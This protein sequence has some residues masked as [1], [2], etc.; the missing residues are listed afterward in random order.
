MTN[1]SPAFQFYPGDFLS[2]ENVISMTFEER[3]L[4]ITLLSN[5][6]IQGSIPSDPDK[7]IKLLPGYSNENGVPELVID[8]FNE[9]DGNSKRLVHPRLDKERTK[10]ADF[11]EA[12]SESGKRGAQKR[13]E[14]HQTKPLNGSAIV[15]P[16]AKNSSLSLSSSSSSSLNLNTHTIYENFEE[17]WN[18]YP[19]KAGN[20]IKARVCYHKS[21]GKDPDKRKLFLE[22]M[23]AYVSN[24]DIE[25]LKHGETFFR[26]WEALVVDTVKSRKNGNKDPTPMEQA[27]LSRGEFVDKVT[28]RAEALYAG[29]EDLGRSGVAELVIVEMPYAERQA[30]R[31]ILYNYQWLDNPP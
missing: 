1:K 13:W 12:K 9:M 4:Y 29:N 19:R 27:T 30:V 20:K 8:C 10:Q 7:I 28:G 11:K 5:C 18:L 16:M 14:N 6:W 2:D 15:S 23:Q 17:D 25:F 26:N 31:L 22:K 3:G 24:T 21:V